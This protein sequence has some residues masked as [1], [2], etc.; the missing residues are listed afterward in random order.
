MWPRLCIGDYYFKA[1]QLDWVSSQLPCREGRP[2]MLQGYVALIRNPCRP[3]VDLQIF[4]H[5]HERHDEYYEMYFARAN[6]NISSSSPLESPFSSRTASRS[7]RSSSSLAESLLEISTSAQLEHHT[8]KDKPLIIGRENIFFGVSYALTA[9]YGILAVL[10][11][12]AGCRPDD[13]LIA[14]VN[15]VCDGNVSVQRSAH[16]TTLGLTVPSGCSLDCS[17]HLGR[18]YRARDSGHA[19]VVH[20]QEPAPRFEETHRHLRLR[21]QTGR[22]RFQHCNDYIIFQLS[23]SRPRQY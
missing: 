15:A 14:S 18:S 16:E 3:H 5:T 11:S 22:D 6:H 10:L 17:D 2:T 23:Q 1:W 9:L 13:S 12:S 8:G 21:F 20:Q 7:S 4:T 19:N